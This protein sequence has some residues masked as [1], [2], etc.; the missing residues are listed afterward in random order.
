[1]ERSSGAEWN[2]RG[3]FDQNGQ[4]LGYQGVGRDITSLRAA[5]E[6]LREKEMQLAHLSRVAALGEMVAGISHEINQPLAAIANFSS[7]MNLLL[8]RETLDADAIEKMNLWASRISTQTDRINKII[9]RLRRFGR[10]GS[11]R[12]S[13]QICDAIREALF[14]TETRTRFAV[15]HIFV[16]VPETLPAVFADRIQIE[17]VLVNLIRNSCDAMEG[18]P[19][20]TRRL[21]IDV[22]VSEDFVSIQV[23]DS[24]SGI[25]ADFAS[26]IFDPFVTSRKEGLGIGLAIS[27]SIV[28]AHGG[29]IKA[30]TDQQCGLFQFTLP[31]SE[32]SQD[33]Q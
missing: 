14:V 31:T 4:L 27:R 5:E 7:A 12:E 1:M 16:Q 20:G 17:Q 24:G 13:F 21:D 8:D 6:K 15:D 25:S 32:L 22:T 11:V 28:E 9:Q 10:P 2:G 23:R 3:L 26:H 30:I 33:E 18:M 19:G 29:E